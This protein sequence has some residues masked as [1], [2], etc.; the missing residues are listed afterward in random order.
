MGQQNISVGKYLVRGCETDHR[1][2]GIYLLL[3]LNEIWSDTSSNDLFP[4]VHTGHQF[5]SQRLK[6]FRGIR[7]WRSSGE[8]SQS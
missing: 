7:V 1:V 4:L 3:C 5:S 2:G 8:Q 6:L